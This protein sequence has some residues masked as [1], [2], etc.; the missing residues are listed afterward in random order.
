MVDDASQR[1]I[2]A[3]AVSFEYAVAAKEP[4]VAH[5]SVIEEI[6]RFISGRH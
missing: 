6:C 3:H 1:T 2:L 4:A 5:D